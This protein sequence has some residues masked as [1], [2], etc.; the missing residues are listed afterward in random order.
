MDWDGVSDPLVDVALRRDGRTLIAN[1]QGRRFEAA[2]GQ[3]MFVFER[4]G[5]YLKDLPVRRRN[6]R[7]QLELRIDQERRRLAESA[8]DAGCIR[9]G[10]R[11]GRKK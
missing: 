3:L 7:P 2:S 8:R 10:E 6:E 1:F 4:V 11:N 9:C 5:L